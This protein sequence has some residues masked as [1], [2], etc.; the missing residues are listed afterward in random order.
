[1]GLLEMKIIMCEKKNVL[2]G[3]NNRLDSAV[4]KLVNL[5]TNYLKHRKKKI[6]PKI[7]GN[8]GIT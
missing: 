2:V 3:I 4:K 8:F 1:M 6:K 5:K 7:L